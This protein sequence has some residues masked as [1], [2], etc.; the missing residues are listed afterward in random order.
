MFKNENSKNEIFLS[1]E[2]RSTFISYKKNVFNK[3]PLFDLLYGL[4][5]KGCPFCSAVYFGKNMRIE[6]EYIK[7][8]KSISLFFSTGRF[9]IYSYFINGCMDFMNEE[10]EVLLKNAQRLKVTRIEP[11]PSR[12]IGEKITIKTM[13]PFVLQ[14]PGSDRK[15]FKNFYITAE[16]DCF[17]NVLNEVTEKRMGYLGVKGFSQIKIKTNKSK[18]D[19]IPHYK[20]YVRATRGEFE[21]K[22]SV[23]TLQFLYDYGIGTRTGQLFGMFRIL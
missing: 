13:S 11:L 19:Q 16:H 12:T 15:D 3:S 6:N 18:I 10:K 14:N 1:K 9:D 20:G 17:E 5:K 2:Y 8:S 4:E 7:I 22:S 21:L 23:E